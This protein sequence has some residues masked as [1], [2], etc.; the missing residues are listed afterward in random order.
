MANQSKS[1]AKLANELDDVIESTLS[2]V[3]Q[4]GGDSTAL[5]AYAADRLRKASNSVGREAR[6]A[7]RKETA[8][9]KA[10]GD[11]ASA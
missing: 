7:Q 11:E 1:P 6:Q 8:R 3:L 9:L 2:T 4:L 10:V 5:L